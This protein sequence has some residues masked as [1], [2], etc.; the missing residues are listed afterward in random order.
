MTRIIPTYSSK[1]AENRDILRSRGI[2]VGRRA[3]ALLNAMA[4]FENE[5][6]RGRAG[7]GPILFPNNG[8]GRVVRQG[9]GLPLDRVPIPSIRMPETRGSLFQE[10]EGQSSLSIPT[11][12][13]LS[14]PPQPLGRGFP[15]SSS[16]DSPPPLE[17]CS[18]PRRP[19]LR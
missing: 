7:R 17:D 18:P 9:R 8:L 19:L 12:T 3:R 1:M 2:F 4:Y 16:P 13:P 10:R 15:P 6:P 11:I 14:T 5:R